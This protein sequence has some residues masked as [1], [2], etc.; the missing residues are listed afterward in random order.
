MAVFAIASNAYTA[1]D[2]VL[3]CSFLARAVLLQIFIIKDAIGIRSSVTRKNHLKSIKV[4][5]K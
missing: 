3:F 5:Q 4:T 1:L 2:G